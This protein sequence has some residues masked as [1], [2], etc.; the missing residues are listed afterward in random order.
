M[1]FHQFSW[2]PYGSVFS[3]RAMSDQIP[4]SDIPQPV[5]PVEPVTS[6]APPV[7]DDWIAPTSTPTRKGVPLVVTVLVA[8]IFGAT[9]GYVAGHQG[10]TSNSVSIQTSNAGHS[11]ALLPSGATIPQLVTKVSPS[12]VSIDVKAGGSEDQGTGMIISADGL[13]LTNNHVISAAITGGDITVTRTG[14]LTPLSATLIG[15]DPANDI[16]LIKID[17]I[18]GLPSV[19]FGNSTTLVVGDAVVAIGNALGLAAGTPTVTQGIVSALGRTV[20]ASDSSATSSETLSNMIQTDAAINPGNSGGPLL[21]ALGHV[22]GMN[23][24]VA[25]T[26]PDGSSAQNIGFAIPASRLEIE[27][28]LLTKG[29]IIT[30]HK[31]RLG[32]E[33]MTVDPSVAQSDNLTVTSGALVLQVVMGGSADK[34]GI[35]S[36]DVI[37][38]MNGRSITNA[39][40]VTAFMQ[41]HR[42]GNKV[43]VGLVRG[44]THL[45]VT[46]T[47][48]IG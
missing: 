5:P 32:V 40:Q 22:I 12:V 38:A 3:L 31:A 4:T 39:D 16:A 46:A 7:L 43:R 42:P 8:A 9:A 37:I 36:G 29:G 2:S 34:A 48:G 13:V 14:G 28:P 17:N 10:R 30:S 26:L 1:K 24:A 45:T 6:V 35:H 20:T 15:T 19:T 41:S 11:G 25:G 21:D 23:T 18:S 27:I 33:I 44:S 47:L